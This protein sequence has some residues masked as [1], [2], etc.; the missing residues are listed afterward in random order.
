MPKSSKP[1]WIDWVKSR[2]RDIILED[3]INGIIPYEEEKCSPDHAWN[4]WYCFIPEIIEEKVVYSQ[5]KERF[6][7]HQRQISK[8]KKQSTREEE[9][10]QYHA[11][12]HPRK[13]YNTRGE[14]VF[15]LHP[16]KPLLREDVLDGKHKQLTPMQ[17]HKTR[18][19]Y[20]EFALDAFSPLIYQAVR[21]QK[22]VHTLELRRAEKLRT[23]RGRQ[24]EALANQDR[25]MN[26]DDEEL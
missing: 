23:Q 16:A 18:P 5:F 12:L 26:V 21:S 3:L 2:S 6:V 8:K 14:L 19:E 24:S 17:L 15:D 25:Q 4:T 22:F 13:T 10:F 7:A 11:T 9:A 20:Q 1:G